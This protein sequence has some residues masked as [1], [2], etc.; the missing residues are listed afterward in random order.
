MSFQGVSLRGA[1]GWHDLGGDGGGVEDGDDEEEEDNVDGRGGCCRSW[2][3][4]VMVLG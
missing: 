4:C 1:G 2:R 3:W